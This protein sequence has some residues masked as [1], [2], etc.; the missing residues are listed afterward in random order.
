MHALLHIL[1]QLRAAH[2]VPVDVGPVSEHMDRRPRVE[3]SLE[4]EVEQAKQLASL[5]NEGQ[6]LLN[7][8]KILEVLYLQPPDRLLELLSRRGVPC[9]GDALALCLLVGSLMII[10]G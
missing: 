6:R 7:R 1:E 8:E 4:R 10:C 2:N 3:V 9:R 5:H